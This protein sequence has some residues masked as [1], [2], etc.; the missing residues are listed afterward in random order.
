[1]SDVVRYIINEQGDR[2]GVV[3][4]WESYSRLTSSSALDS[5]CLVGLSLDELHALAD[6]KLTIA[7]QSY[8]DELLAKNKNAQLSA[9][10]TIALD[11]ILAQADQIMIL[12][13]RARYTL[14]RLQELASAS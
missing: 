8:L 9:D 13:A 6:S 11:R 12:K 5:D 4:D 7:E 10:E 3:L 1:M 14:Q 2:L